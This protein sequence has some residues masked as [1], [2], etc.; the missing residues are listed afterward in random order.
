MGA[1]AEPGRGP[2]RCRVVEC[3]A[4]RGV[5]GGAGWGGVLG[6]IYGRSLSLSSCNCSSSWPC[7]ADVR[8]QPPPPS[9]LSP[10][11]VVLLT[12]RALQ[13]HTNRRDTEYGTSRRRGGGR[14]CEYLYKRYGRCRKIAIKMGIGGECV[15][16]VLGG[17]FHAKNAT[18]RSSA[19]R[20]SINPS[21]L[22][23][24]RRAAHPPVL[25]REPRSLLLHF[26]C[27]APDANTGT[28]THSRPRVEAALARV[29]AT[30]EC[31]AKAFHV[32]SRC[33]VQLHGR[34]RREVLPAKAWV[35]GCEIRRSERVV[36][37]PPRV[38]NEKKLG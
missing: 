29:H 30:T 22:S 27:A 35:G 34:G 2:V 1:Q 10:C 36:G 24:H 19:G 9:G 32:V 18:T 28:Y 17:V 25:M 5:G 15:L 21:P 6:W 37:N 12:P 11:C 38:W 31:V 14:H 7:N 3:A 20:R 16:N 26:Q 8:A 13:L 23:W 4:E 33:P